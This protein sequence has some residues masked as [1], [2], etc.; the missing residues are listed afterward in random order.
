MA[1]EELKVVR[2]KSDFYRDGFYK[3]FIALSMALA[4][5]VLLIAISVSF[6]LTKPR[7]VSF[8]S[9][10]EWRI[11]APVSVDQPYLTVAD[12]LQWVSEV[13]PN[14]FTYDFIN[15]AT[16]L[17]GLEQYFTPDGWKRVNNQ[18]NVY[19]NY[20]TVKNSKLFVS[21]RPAGAPIIQN[22]G[23]LEQRYAWWVKMPVDVSYSSVEKGNTQTLVVQVLVVRVPTLTNLRGVA[24]D[25]III[26][27]DGGKVDT[28]G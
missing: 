2:L 16:Q 23:I 27:G 15:Y 4:A 6:V 18:I 25:N 19:A 22:Q 3:V 10:N 12:L 7:P 1:G 11:V 28:N 26:G 24:I 8:S 17:Q 20:N 14:V 5:I 21:A 13:L 9:D